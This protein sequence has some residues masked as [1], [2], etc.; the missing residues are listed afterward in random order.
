MKSVWMF[1]VLLLLTS[2]CRF[3][4]SE[5]A[6]PEN[7]PRIAGVIRQVNRP[8]H[9]FIFE[10]ESRFPPGTELSILRNGQK[11]GEAKVTGL[12]E[13]KFQAADILQGAPLPG[14]LCEPGFMR[15]PPTAAS[16]TTAP[17][18]PS[19]PAGSVIPN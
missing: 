17:K 12:W 1:S 18:L 3:F 5:T 8:E 7:L 13:K 2:G 15:L 10:T 11:I 19:P 4:H 6:P 9:Y 14:D 16:G